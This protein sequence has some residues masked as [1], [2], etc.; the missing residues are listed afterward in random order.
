VLL[1]QARLFI[2]PANAATKIRCQGQSPGR[3]VQSQ[4]RN[5]CGLTGFFPPGRT[6]TEAGMRF[7]LILRKQK[8]HE[9]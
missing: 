5:S 9:A 8:V 1:K 6:V 2:L 3:I 7:G 4:R